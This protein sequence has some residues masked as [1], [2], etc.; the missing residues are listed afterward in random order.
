MCEKS[1]WRAM[2][3]ARSVRLMARRGSAVSAPGVRS[4]AASPG[5]EGGTRIPITRAAPSTVLRT[6]SVNA[7]RRTRRQRR[8][9]GSR[10]TADAS[11]DEGVMSVP[12]CTFAGEVATSPPRSWVQCARH[13]S[14]PLQRQRLISKGTYSNMRQLSATPRA[15]QY[16]DRYATFA[17]TSVTNNPGG[18]NFKEFQSNLVFRWEYRPGPACSSSGTRAGKGRR[19]GRGTPI[20]RGMCEGCCSCT[21]RTR[22]S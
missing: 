15:A 1:L 13:S 18:F 12:D 17:D 3:R 21:Q 7:A 11:L 22:C 10:N 20:S 19:Q 16:D 8:P 6:P 4:P 14:W 9:V 2:S 5:R